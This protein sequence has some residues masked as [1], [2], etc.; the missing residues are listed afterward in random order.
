[1]IQVP[2]TGFAPGSVILAAGH[3]PR[4]HEFQDSVSNLYVPDGT[5][6]ILVQSCDVAGNFNKGVRL[7]SGEWAWFLG[8]DHEFSPYTLMRLLSREVD[9]V[10]PITPCK[11]PFGYPFVLHGIGGGWRDDMQT[12]SWEELS[13]PGLKALQYGDFIGQAGMLVQK[14]VLD[15]IGYPWFKCGKFDEGRLQEDMWF[16]HELQELGYTVWVDTEIVFDHY[17]LGKVTAKR[18]NGVWTPTL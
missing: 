6:F 9:V 4:H 11:Q 12:Y 7:L 2:G 5:K 10:V 18:M 16:C 14:P 8:D 13:G 17:M 3:Q 15:K 1:M